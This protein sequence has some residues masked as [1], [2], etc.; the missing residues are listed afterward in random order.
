MMQ[1]VQPHLA[2]VDDDAEGAAL[3]DFLPWRVQG[4]VPAAE[5]GE[6][7]EHVLPERTQ[8]VHRRVAVAA[9]VVRKLLKRPKSPKVQRAADHTRPGVQRTG[10]NGGTG[11][12]TKASTDHRPQPPLPSSHMRPEPRA[13]TCMYHGSRSRPTLASFGEREL[14]PRYTPLVY[15]LSLSDFLLLLF[16]THSLKLVAEVPFECLVGLKPLQVLH[17]PPVASDLGRE[18]LRNRLVFDHVVELVHHLERDMGHMVKRCRKRHL[19]GQKALGVAKGTWWGKRHLVAQKALDGAKG[20][21][22]GKRH[23]V[24]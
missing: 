11:I 4:L 3:V 23:L 21:W 20:T 6:H 8:I 19:V 18:L 14:L 15:F 1:R 10:D 16:S 9:R 13:D 7:Q 5:V 2:R 17:G 24:G 22:W 12:P